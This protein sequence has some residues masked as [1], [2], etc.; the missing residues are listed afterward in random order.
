MGSLPPHGSPSTAHV[1]NAFFCI[2]IVY[3]MCTSSLPSLLKHSSDS[4]SPG[5]FTG[6]GAGPS[7]SGE[8]LP[9]TPSQLE[10]RGQ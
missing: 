10:G 7:C 5:E 9:S 4:T 1:Q 6:E 8:G 3:E 2:I